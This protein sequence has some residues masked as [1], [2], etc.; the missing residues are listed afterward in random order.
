MGGA[1]AILT[2]NAGSSTLKFALFDD[3]G[4]RVA[5][6]S[7][8]G[9]GTAEPAVLC[10]TV[11]PAS[12]PVVLPGVGFDLERAL[13][14]LLRQLH[15][16]GMLSGL[17]V[18]VHRVVHGGARF[19]GPVCIDADVMVELRRLAPL[20]PLH[21]NANLRGVEV[22]GQALPGLIQFAAFDTA[23]FSAL[24]EVETLLPLPQEVR[25]HGVRRYGFH[26]LA[27]E[28]L[29]ASLRAR[30]VRSQG[31][32]LLAHLGSGCSMAAVCDGQPVATSMGF[33]AL[34]GLMMA[35]RSGSLDPGVLLHLLDQGWTGSSLRDLLY[36]RSG[37][38]GVSGLSGDWRSLQGSQ[39]PR[40][41]QAL[42]LFT[43]RAT[44]EMGALVACLRGLD[45]L[46]FSGGIG[47]HDAP[48]RAALGQTLD[49]LGVRI[50]AARNG[51]ARGGDAVRIDGDDS[52]VEVWVIPAD[53][54]QVLSRVGLAA[55]PVAGAR[56]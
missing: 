18:A 23:F 16:R 43:H 31:R 37:L 26:G 54:E 34:D 46:V 47:Q 14:A 39:S 41:R 36:R 15:L 55:L 11:P 38:L 52:G 19:S 29:M 30:S 7:V 8:E 40:A 25:A 42:A 17:R 9:R 45:L 10:W 51:A 27:Y 48:L 21:Q 22:L 28:H 3:T 5:G 53:E 1:A 33:S 24:P 49:F 4:Q 35:T 56:A 13:Q 2:V 12:Q 32:V 44:R 6:G 50:D 20:A